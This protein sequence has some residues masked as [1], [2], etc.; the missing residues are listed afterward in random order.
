MAIVIASPSEQGQA[1]L[2]ALLNGP[3]GTPPP[4]ILPNF[5]KPPNLDIASH[6]SVAVQIVLASLAV[7]IRLYTRYFL[8][9]SVGY[10]D[11]TSVISWLGLIGYTVC[12]LLGTKAGAGVH[13]WNLQLREFFE[14]LYWVNIVS[15]V[16]SF[17]VFVVKLSILLQYSRIFNPARKRDLPTFVAFQICIWIMLLFYLVACFFVIFECSPREK[18]WNK[19]ETTGYCYNGDVRDKASGIF[20]VLSDFAIFILPM[21]SIWKLQM[22]LRKKLL[23]SIVFAV[24]LFACLMSVIRAYYIWRIVESSDKS[25]FFARWGQWAG[26]ELAAGIVLGC[27]PVFP[28][29]FQHV[30]PRI[31]GMFIRLKKSIT[32]YKTPPAAFDSDPDPYTRLHGESYTLREL[33][34]PRL[35]VKEPA[36]AIIATRRD[37]LEY[38][39]LE[40]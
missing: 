37:D 11:Y 32:R 9:R 5:D 12:C 21:P 8:L 40:L 30:G 39:Y 25:Y 19:L 13:M 26:A 33:E 3:A 7:L 14:L 10:D 1:Q 34:G 15:I 35:Q 4:G 27:F 20:S 22:P 18:I 38:G 28:R 16:Y 36:A 2:D 6:L 17:F 31:Y 23:T 29:F 24:G